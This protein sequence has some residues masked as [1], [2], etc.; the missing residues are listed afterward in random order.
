MAGISQA[1]PNYL[2]ETSD[3]DIKETPG[4]KKRSNPDT[5]DVSTDDNSMGTTDGE[6][7]SSD[8]NGKRNQAKIKEG[9]KTN[10]TQAEKSQPKSE[11][12]RKKRKG[13]E[14]V[15][16]EMTWICTECREAECATK[17]DSPL[18]VCEGPCMRPFHYPCAGLAA[19][20]AESEEWWCNDCLDKRHQCAS[21]H[22]YGVDGVDVLKC[23]HRNCGLFFHESCLNMYDVDIRVTEREKSLNT[24]GSASPVVDAE[25]TYVPK[26]ICPAHRCWTCSGG[27][28]PRREERNDND[29]TKK[30]EPPILVKKK[31]QK[32]KRGKKR[33]IEPLSTSFL[34]KKERLYVSAM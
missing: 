1:S 19:L 7:K 27:V 15:A 21:C 3:C 25:Q 26:F 10:K 29:G 4:D 28:P 13:D 30:E 17:P 12:S 11:K 18:L 22:E 5:N 24:L 34:E 2:L 8:N 9:G 16:L 32:A 14:S 31:S 6:L 33:K 20:P 23:D